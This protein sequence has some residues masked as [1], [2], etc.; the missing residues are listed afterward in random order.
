MDQSSKK[1]KLQAE[2]KRL[3]PSDYFDKWIMSIIILKAGGIDE[4]AARKW[5][6]A[7]YTH[8]DIVF[9]AIWHLDEIKID[10]FSKYAS[11]FA[12]CPIP[13]QQFK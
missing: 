7:T 13:P 4:T 5:S 8:D 11:E 2:M 1:A 12:P 6:K 9:N 10:D 3:H